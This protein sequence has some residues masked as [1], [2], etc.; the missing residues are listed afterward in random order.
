VAAHTR[1]GFVCLWLYEP[2]G[3]E[4]IPIA[5]APAAKSRPEPVSIESGENRIVVRSFRHDETLD[6]S[7]PQKVQQ[8]L[9]KSLKN[10]GGSPDDVRQRAAERLRLARRDVIARLTQLIRCLPR[11][12]PI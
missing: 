9:E 7:H 1:A 3:Q 8:D 5:Y 10:G 11:K 4:L 2:F 12:P 6:A